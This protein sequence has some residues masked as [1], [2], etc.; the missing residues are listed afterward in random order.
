MCL[1]L[2]TSLYCSLQEN[3]E[4]KVL[5]RIACCKLMQ[6]KINRWRQEHEDWEALAAFA[7]SKNTGRRFKNKPQSDLNTTLDVNIPGENAAAVDR[8]NVSDK[9]AV[10]SFSSVQEDEILDSDSASFDDEVRNASSDKLRT[11]AYLL[12]TSHDNKPLAELRLQKQQPLDG[13]CCSV[14]HPDVVVKQISLDEL[15]DELCLPPPDDEED[16]R[17]IEP[18]MSSFATKITKDFFVV[19][20]DEESVDGA[21]ALMRAAASSDTDGDNE[22]DATSSD[23]LQSSIKSATMFAKSLSHHR[24]RNAART[25]REDRRWKLS[26]RQNHRQKMKH[27]DDRNRGKQFSDKWFMKSRGS[28]PKTHGSRYHKKNDTSSRGNAKVNAKYVDSVVL[29]HISFLSC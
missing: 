8:N 13:S 21:K 17:S 12:N 11:S 4:E 24:P 2:V 16:D 5:T 3:L 22:D 15:G 25:T 10:R 19:S 29:F 6:Q 23:V 28:F 9:T 14:V 27:S 18:A 26:D 1:P 7:L 20:S